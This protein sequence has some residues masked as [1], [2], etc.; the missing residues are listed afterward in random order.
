MGYGKGD[1]PHAER[2]ASRILSLPM[3]PE[4]SDRQ[5]K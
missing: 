4:L 1:F 3:F 5:I 2:L